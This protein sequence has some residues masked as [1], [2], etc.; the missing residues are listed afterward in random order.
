M[1]GDEYLTQSVYIIRFIHVPNKQKPALFSR[2][3]L[4]GT[5]VGQWF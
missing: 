2:E 5:L 4:V 1:Q 3:V